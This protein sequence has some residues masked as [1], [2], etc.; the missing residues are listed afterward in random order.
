M[1]TIAEA[2]TTNAT[3][4]WCEHSNSRPTGRR[5]HSM[6]VVNNHVYI[7]GGALL[8]CLCT[9]ANG[10]KMCSSKN[11]YSSELWHFDVSSSMFTLLEPSEEEELPRG[12]EQH[13]ATVL[14]N[15]DIVIIGG[16]SSSFDEDITE[17]LE[18]LNE[19]WK[20][21]DPH[22]VTSHVISGEDSSITQLPMDLNQSYLPSHTIN[23]DLGDD[24]CVEDLQ[25]SLSLDHGC[26][27]GIE[28]ISLTGPPAPSDQ[29]SIQSRHYQTKLFVSTAENR[30]RD[31]RS[32]LFD[33]I[34]SDAVEEAVLSYSGLPK[35]GAY[36]PAS[37]LKETF[38]GLAVN[39][40]WKLEIS[41]SNEQREYTG[42]FLDWELHMQTKSC[43]P[44]VKWEQIS[45]P[46]S[47]Q[48]RYGH[49]AIA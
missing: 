7:F 9:V 15:G 10:E 46:P 30:E 45:V 37:S 42:S 47:F 41:T 48:P 44:R 31:C 18:P 4:T 2:N 27:Q 16:I 24:I 36:R 23:V 19:V 29:D 20:L 11:I 28:Y 25:M 21:S 43:T 49:T 5:G 33:L 39:G 34:F 35:Q 12:R 22:H 13:S 14:P 26:P 1:T 38:Q 40:E 8:K 17:D 32:S 6:T 3:W